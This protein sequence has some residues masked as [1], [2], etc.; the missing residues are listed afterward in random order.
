MVHARSRSGGLLRIFCRHHEERLLFSIFYS[1]GESFQGNNYFLCSLLLNLNL[2][3]WQKS[4]I[5]IKFQTQS[6]LGLKCLQAAG[7]QLI[8]RESFFIDTYTVID[9]RHGSVVPILRYLNFLDTFQ[10]QFSKISRANKEAS[11]RKLQCSMLLLL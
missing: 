2:T 11:I 5:P 4:L 7:H 9:R 6:S 3:L 10:I 8:R 1:R